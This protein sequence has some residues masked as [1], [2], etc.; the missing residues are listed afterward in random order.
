MNAVSTVLIVTHLDSPPNPGS[1]KVRKP[2]LMNSVATAVDGDPFRRRGP[3]SIRMWA[4]QR[5]G[6]PALTTIGQVVSSGDQSGSETSEACY[7]LNGMDPN[8]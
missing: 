5:V 7:C 2:L 8:G 6:L 4:A 3:T 1:V